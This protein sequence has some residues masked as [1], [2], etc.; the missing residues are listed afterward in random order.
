[1]KCFIHSFIHAFVSFFIYNTVDIFVFIYTIHL[2]FNS[3]QRY[4]TK[5]LSYC[6]Q[7]NA[8]K[9]KIPGTP[10]FF[11]DAKHWNGV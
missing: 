4:G 3:K 6:Y 5:E 1:M 7:L 11:I 2:L 9:S 10:G 8:S